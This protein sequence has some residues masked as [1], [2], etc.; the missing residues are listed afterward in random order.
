[1]LMAAVFVPVSL[2]PLGYSG[3]LARLF[4]AVFSVALG[5]LVYRQVTRLAGTRAW[6]LVAVALF[7]FSSLA[8]GWYP[9]VKT[10]ALPTLLLFIAYAVLS[11]ASRWWWAAS[12]VLI[13]LATDCR[14]YL[15]AVVPAFLLELY[16]TEENAKRRLMQFAQF[17]MGFL[18]ALLPNAFFF[19]IEPRTFVVNTVR[20]Q[21]I[22][23]D[24]R[25][26]PGSSGRA[27]PS[28]SSC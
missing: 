24:F 18:L 13:G 28:S 17:C 7:T 20:N 15:I 16:L 9:L 8:F 4:S 21:V 14:A 6:D 22:R 10:L 3:Y 11:S 1:M 25:F 27:A 2:Y 23:T 5:L 26:S 19:L 12:G